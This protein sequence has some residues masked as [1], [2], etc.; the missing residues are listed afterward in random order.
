[1][2]YCDFKT[3]KQRLFIFLTFS[4]FKISLYDQHMFKFRAYLNLNVLIADMLINYFYKYIRIDMIVK[5]D[6]LFPIQV[7]MLH[8][9]QIFFQQSPPPI[10]G[11]STYQTLLCPIIAKECI[12]RRVVVKVP[13]SN[14]DRAFLIKKLCNYTKSS[15]QKI[16]LRKQRPKRVDETLVRVPPPLQLNV[17]W[18][19]F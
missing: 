18:S 4:Q 15:Q 2:C 1:M 14:P 16:E 17:T 13:G 5:Q 7:K 3:I 12:H 11:F 8:T 9:I 10:L 19:M 6:K